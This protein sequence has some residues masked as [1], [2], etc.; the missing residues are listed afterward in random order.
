MTD[1]FFIELIKSQLL[2]NP[3]GERIYELAKIND[4]DGMIKMYEGGEPH[5]AKPSM[6]M[7]CS[8]GCSF[9]CML[10][11]DI[12]DYEKPSIEKAYK[13]LS[14]DT[15]ALIR[16]RM[17]KKLRRTKGLEVGDRSKLRIMCGFNINNECTIY[18]NRPIS[19][20]S[21]HSGDYQAC[22]IGSKE[23]SDVNI[24]KWAAPVEMKAMLEMAFGLVLMERGK[25]VDDISETLENFI[26]KLK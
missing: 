8:K 17:K 22:E 15:K 25:K 19:C 5:W 14:P 10:N 20:R 18:S 6:P 21:H 2:A 4:F 12:M 11:V 13:A 1:T 16:T 24:P 9:C 7:A 3:L 26:T 23:G